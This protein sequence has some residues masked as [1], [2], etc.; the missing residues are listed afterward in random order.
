MQETIRAAWFE[1]FGPAV[2][3]LTVGEQPMSV[4]EPG[5]VLLRI[6]TS[7][8]NPSDVKKRAGSFPNLLDGGL[9]S[10]TAIARV[11]L[12][13]LA[14]AWRTAGL[15]SESGCTRRSMA[16]ASTLLQNMWQSTIAEISDKLATDK[17]K[18][19]V[20][21][22]VPLSEIAHAHELIEQ[23]G[24]RGCVVLTLD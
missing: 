13:L 23:G 16:G 8:V 14:R 4:M 3:V 10:R 2:K 11:P 21:H 7:G 22:T 24:F 19:R 1:E 15:A 17:L 12:S 5:H 18:H 20:A 6:E 9:V